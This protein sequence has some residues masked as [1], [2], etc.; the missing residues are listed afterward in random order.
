MKDIDKDNET[1]HSFWNFIAEWLPGYYSRNDVLESDI[2]TRYVSDEEVWDKDLEWINQ[3]HR[4]DKQLVLERLIDLETN[5]AKEALSAYYEKA[6]TKAYC[7]EFT[8]NR[9]CR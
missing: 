7:S 2:L 9:I 8:P 6:L 3:Y 4:G 1:Y 5:F